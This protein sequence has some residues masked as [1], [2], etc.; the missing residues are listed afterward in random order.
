MSAAIQTTAIASTPRA[1]T[2]AALGTP[3]RPGGRDFDQ[4]VVIRV[5]LVLTYLRLHIPQETVAVLFGATQ[6]DVS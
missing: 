3:G 5:T 1:R 6:P 4:P 2:R